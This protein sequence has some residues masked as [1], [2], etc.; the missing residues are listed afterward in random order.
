MGKL[1]GGGDTENLPSAIKTMAPRD[2]FATWWNFYFPSFFKE[3]SFPFSEKNR[4]PSA[5][6]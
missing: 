3:L 6:A 4:R 2:F 5:D 1:K